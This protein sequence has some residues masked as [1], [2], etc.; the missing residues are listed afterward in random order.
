VTEITRHFLRE[1]RRDMDSHGDRAL[2]ERVQHLI[3][4]YEQLCEDYAQT[5]LDRDT[6]LARLEAFV[7][8]FKEVGT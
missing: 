1:L 5:E 8:K 2:A 7:G 6:F 4:A 3:A